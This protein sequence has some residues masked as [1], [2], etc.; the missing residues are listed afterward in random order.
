MRPLGPDRAKPAASRGRKGANRMHHPCAPSSCTTPDY[1]GV[2]GRCIS[3]DLRSWATPA[4][5][6]TGGVARGLA[7]LISL[8]ERENQEHV[9]HVREEFVITSRR[10]KPWT[11]AS[12]GGE[13]LQEE[14][15]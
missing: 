9:G 4:S 13:C 7:L 8:Q 3:Q 6:M 14:G 1:Q 12:Q 5:S 10:D 2:V 11:P 15:A